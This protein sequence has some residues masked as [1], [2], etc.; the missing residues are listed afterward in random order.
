MSENNN[1]LTSTLERLGLD[2]ETALMYEVESLDCVTAV[3]DARNVDLVRALA[4]H[5]NV[6]ISLRQSREHAPR[7]ADHVAHLLSDH[8]QDR[9]IAMHGHLK[10]ATPRTRAIQPAET[11]GEKHGGGRGR[12]G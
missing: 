5:L 10:K 4:D 8:R 7:D 3:D 12:E 6:D 2:L 11:Q 9:H 1:I